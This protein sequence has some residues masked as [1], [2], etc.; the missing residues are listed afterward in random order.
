M[1]ADD[2][3]CL[4][5]LDRQDRGSVVY[6]AFGSIATIQTQLQFDEL[7]FGL[8]LTGRPFLWVVRP[9]YG[10]SGTSGEKFPDGFLKRVGD[11]GKIVEWANQEKVLSHP[12]VN[13]GTKGELGGATAPPPPVSSLKLHIFLGIFGI[14]R[15]GI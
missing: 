9:N 5:W 15:R 10:R 4:A 8:E 1:W 7:A 14:W 12:S 13:G 6:V 3:S 11:R 2:R